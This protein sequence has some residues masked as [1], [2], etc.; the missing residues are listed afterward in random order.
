MSLGGN[1]RTGIAGAT[2][3]LQK[4]DSQ[5]SRT[6]TRAFRAGQQIGNGIKNIAKIGIASVTAGAGIVAASLKMAG[7]FE[8]Q[9]NTINTIAHDTPAQ[10]KGVGDEIRGIAKKTGLSLDD[11]T[12]SYY[13]L[14]SA[15]VKTADA[16]AVL[17]D[18][19]TLGIGGLATTA[20]TVD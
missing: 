17:N 19:V 18:A 9:L 5:V 12:K 15:G 14:L 8:A 20:Q 10:L 13:D 4:F 16:Q 11:L 2:R 7:D 3:D 6:S 1:F